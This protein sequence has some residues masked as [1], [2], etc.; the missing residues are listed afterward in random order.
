MKTKLLLIISV[1]SILLTACGFYIGPQK[2]D[3]SF[4]ELSLLH[5]TVYETQTYKVIKTPGVVYAEGLSH[6]DWGSDDVEVLPL[7]VDV[8]EP[9]GAPGNRPAILLIHGGGYQQGSRLY[10]PIVQMCNYFASR[11][12]V[13]FSIDYRLQEDHGT[14]PQEW[15]DA[16]DQNYPEDIKD[17]VMAVYPA[18]RD[19]KAA[20][21][22]I[23][24]N[25]SEFQI[26]TEYITALGGS[27]GASMAIM[28]GVTEEEN[29]R[30]ELSISDDPT[31]HSTHLNQ[32]AKI[33]TIIDL[34]GSTGN[35]DWLDL[36]YAIESFDAADAPIMIAH[37][38]LDDIVDFSN[39]E[40]IRGKYEE[41]GI[42]YKF[43]ALEGESHS[44]WS[45]RVDGMDLAQ[46]SFIFI[47]SWQELTVVE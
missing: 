27:A 26:N 17:Q 46:L 2:S 6:S 42:D 33:H 7:L 36:A 12:W 25:A 40:Y 39:A 15:E 35:I 18:N 5:P 8:Y 28:L 10:P 41:N 38:R 34:W 16:I 30:D 43:Y 11:G 32:P 20:L 44:A 19:A 9:D 4:E 24:A 3:S 22:W 1:L 21:R 29:F 31:L 47:V 23:N 37:G 14:V 45:A 13:A